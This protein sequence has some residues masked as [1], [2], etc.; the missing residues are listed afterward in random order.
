MTNVELFLDAK[1]ATSFSVDELAL[2]GFNCGFFRNE[3]L[4]QRRAT[5]VDSWSVMRVAA[6]VEL[7]S[8][9]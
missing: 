9:T 2:D 3:R 8:S 1:P 4:Q 6:Y 7:Y 5:F